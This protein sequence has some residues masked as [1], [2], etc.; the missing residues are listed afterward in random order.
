[1][2]GTPLYT[3][4]TMVCFSAILAKVTSEEIK[5]ISKVMDMMQAEVLPLVTIA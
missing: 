4:E 5:T 2:D 3:S 1:M